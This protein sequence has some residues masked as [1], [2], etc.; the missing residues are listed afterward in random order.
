VVGAEGHSRART[1]CLAHAPSEARTAALRRL[2]DH[3]LDA[4]RDRVAAQHVMPAAVVDD[5]VLEYRKFMSLVFELRRPAMFSPEVDEV[6]H[7]HILFTRD[8]TQLCQGVFG[9][10]LHHDPFVAGHPR[11]DL[12]AAWAKFERAYRTLFG[13]PSY[14]WQRPPEPDSDPN[15]A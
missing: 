9:G 3:D 1:R 8:Y 11:P 14:L 13:E 5:A 4:V 12:Q 7:A 2:W 10:Y 15:G 6:W